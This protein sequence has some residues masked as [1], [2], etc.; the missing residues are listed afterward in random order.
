MDFVLTSTQPETD[1]EEKKIMIPAVV[2]TIVPTLP[3]AD[4]KVKT[5]TPTDYKREKQNIAPGKTTDASGPNTAPVQG[6]YFYVQAGAFKEKSR[7]TFT[8]TKLAEKT[9][10][11]TGIKEE[12][13]YYKVITGPFKS[14]KVAVDQMTAIQNEG[15]D[16]FIRKSAEKLF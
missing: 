4:T 7:A 13:G 5:E 14:W 8:L 1:A 3:V 6:K 2:D 10:S 16:C 11:P 15:F 12:N 9:S